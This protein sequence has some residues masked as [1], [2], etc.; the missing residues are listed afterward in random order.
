M[1]EFKSNFNKLLGQS[2]HQTEQLAELL[3]RVTISKSGLAEEANE[4]AMT[5][6]KSTQEWQAERDS[7]KSAAKKLKDETEQ[8]GSLMQI[9]GEEHQAVRRRLEQL[10]E[11]NSK[12][13]E[14]LYSKTS[15]ENETLRSPYE[16]ENRKLKMLLNGQKIEKEKLTSLHAEELH[17]LKVKNAKDAN[18]L[19]EVKQELE[20]KIREINRSRQEKSILEE[21]L[22]QA[23]QLIVN[24]KQELTRERKEISDRPESDKEASVIDQIK[25]IMNKVYKEVTKKFQPEETYSFKDIKATVGTVIRVCYFSTLL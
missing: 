13:R 1:S 7:L 4:K 9:K 2:N 25:T 6:D 21:K 22:L 15:R 5:E 14:S 11:E 16:E 19:K 23:N 17:E 12:L 10:E 3:N 20:E 18:M 24:L 8:L